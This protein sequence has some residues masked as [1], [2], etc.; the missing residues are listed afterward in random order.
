MAEPA[1][2][3]RRLVS[4]D[5]SNAGPMILYGNTFVIDGITIVVEAESL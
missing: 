3:K 2:K 5:T 1:R 4:K